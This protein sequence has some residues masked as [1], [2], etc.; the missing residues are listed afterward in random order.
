MKDDF[1]AASQH[2]LLIAKAIKIFNLDKR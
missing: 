2:S 1:S